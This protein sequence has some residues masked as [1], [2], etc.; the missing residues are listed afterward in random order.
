MILDGFSLE[1][2]GSTED[3]EY[4]A[5]LKKASCND[6]YSMYIN[7]PQGIIPPKSP[8]R[9]F[10]TLYVHSCLTGTDFRHRS[11]LMICIG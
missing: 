2:R 6:P 10:T 9:L 11:P 3:T 7:R 1:E 5:P 8:R 4:D